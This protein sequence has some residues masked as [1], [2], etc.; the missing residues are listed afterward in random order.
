MLKLLTL[1]DF[2]IVEYLELEFKQGLTALTGETG[3]GKS[4][5]LDALELLLGNKADLD[6]IRVGAEQTVL[7]AIFAL[8]TK[9]SLRVYLEENAFLT[10]G[11]ELWIKRIVSR[12]GKNKQYV[13]GHLL[14]VSQLKFIGKFL[15]EF[16]SQ[17]AQYALLSPARQKDILDE[18]AAHSELLLEV[19]R[20]YERCQTAEIR[21][22]EAQQQQARLQSEVEILEWKAKE[23]AEL[24]PLEQEWE[25]L[26]ASYD[27]M[28]KH[29]E[30]LEVARNV[31][32]MITRD[33]GWQEE[34]DRA[35]ASLKELARLTP[36][37]QESELILQSIQ[38][39]L[40]EVCSN[41]RAVYSQS[42]LD[43]E[44]LQLIE[45]RMTQLNAMAK[46][47]LIEP[48]S[49]PQK[50]LEIKEALA[51]AKASQEL[52]S[53]EEE[54]LQAKAAYQACAKRLSD[55]RK[56]AAK[57]F[58][59][60]VTKLMHR[61]AMER[62]HFEVR[63]LA[64]KAGVCGQEDVAFMVTFNQ[65]SALGLLQKV[66]SGGELSRISLAIQVIVSNSSQVPTLIFDE[67]DTGIGGKVATLVGSYLKK[68]ALAQQVLV[69]THL[70]QV[71]VHATQHYRVTK[72]L[73]TGIAMSEIK[74][75]CGQGRV[76]EIARMLGTEKITKLTLN[77]A[78][79]L[80]ELAGQKLY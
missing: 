23:L 50:W 16:H 21:L 18:Y 19:R 31:D 33:Q 32:H 65:G 63:L 40:G 47:Y 41:M 74:E 20:A 48:A 59:Q 35:L 8:P 25:G 43:E 80:L 56:E 52:A 29:S 78:R 24:A 53:L 1:R 4:V 75:L 73:K 51:K 49:L 38:V 34:L 3:A 76:E 57:S 60:E 77:H 28:S 13:N 44:S 9:S 66:A 67:V 11:E 30:L 17:H 55:S 5:L 14:S 45:M 42:E 70:P 7:T 58:S 68:I 36:Y 12:S 26:S 61:L 71:A 72:Q 22:L 79:E 15:L 27:E 69:I 10:E 39:E 62:S 6:Q 64:T 37:F 54:V 2:T 46:K